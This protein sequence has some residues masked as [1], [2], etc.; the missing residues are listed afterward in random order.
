MPSEHIH[1]DG[2][3]QGVGFR[4]FV[5]RL[6]TERG[7]HGWVRNNSRGVDIE[8]S[9]DPAVLEDFARALR[10][11][12]PPLAQIT[13]LTRR[14]IPENDF[15]GEFVIVHSEEAGGFTLVSPDVATCADCLRELFDPAD[16]RYRYPFINC[17]NCG[18]RFSIIQGL[19]YDRP[20]TTMSVFP[21]CA[22]CRAEYE[23]PLDRR[24]HAQPNACPEC[25]PQ[26]WLEAEARGVSPSTLHASPS[27]QIPAAARLLLEGKILAVKGLGGFH[28]A[29]DATNTAAVRALRE[30]KPRPRKPLAVMMR[31]LDMV[32]AFCQVSPEE[33]ALLTSPAA[34]ILLLTPRPATALS[35]EVAPGQRSLGVML[36]YTPLHHLLL[37]E[38]NRPL[39]LTSGNRQN[40]PIARTNAEAR[41]ALAPIVDGFLWHDREIHN[42]NDDSVWMVTAEGAVPL[43]RSRGYA[44]RPV[45]LP[46]ESEAPVLAAGSQMKNTFCLLTGGQAFLSQH[47]GEMDYLETWEFF[48]ESVRRYRDLFGIRPQVIAH[49][50]HP[51]FTLAALDALHTLA[52]Q[53]RPVPVQHHHAHIAACMAENGVD[54]PVIGVALDGTGYGTDGTIWGGEILIADFRDFERAAHFEIFPLPGGEAAIREPLR[55]AFGLL[56]ETFGEVP[57]PL[58]FAARLPAPVRQAVQTQIERGLNA[59]PTSSCGRL[60]DA[61]SALLG[62]CERVTYEGQAAIEMETL[63]ARVPDAEP[64]PLEVAAS[65]GVWQI[66]SRALFRAA[67]E[68]LLRG[69]EPAR[70]AA[71]FHRSVIESVRRAVLNIHRA[72]GLDAVALSGGCFQ[73]R[74]LLEGLARALRADGLT[75]YTHHQVPANDGGL[76][77]GQAVIAAHRPAGG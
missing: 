69:T 30:R 50:L 29:C 39:V 77:L 6:A 7:L 68:D 16:R 58:D 64:Y 17:T 12:A 36:P 23:N 75:V 33:A 61:V 24:F 53:A 72:R 37:R 35:P 43:R 15:G 22:D 73:N 5:Y 56:L 65:G 32:R 31:D 71:R 3:V 34:P 8:I 42:R 66:P 40:E 60:F 10:E 4:P 63:A 62:I 52:P 76:S 70:I 49:D 1:I 21:M 74:I 57:A 13:A 9:G 2:I 11:Q 54:E 46:W 44:P 55:T 67:A 26:V 51:D 28:I 18:P 20:N 47:I 38:V 19:P 59:P 48:T 27:S 25:G 41:T 14:S 45:A